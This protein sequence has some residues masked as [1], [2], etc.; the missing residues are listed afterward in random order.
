MQFHWQ[1]DPA[2]I[3]HVEEF[4]ASHEN[5]S[6]VKACV[7]KNLAK[8]KPRVDQDEFWKKMVCARLTSRQRSGPDSP[9]AQFMEKKEFPLSFADIP[10]SND[11][12][13]LRKL[14]KTTLKNH[15]GI[16]FYRRISEDLSE[17]MDRLNAEQGW[18]NMLGKLNELATTS[19]PE[20]EREVARY[21]QKLLRGFG[22]KQSRNLL[23]SLGLT[24]YEIPID[25]RVARWLKEFN[26]PVNVNAKSLADNGYYEFILDGIKILCEKSGVYP[27]VL[28]AAIFAS[29]EK[30]PKT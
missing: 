20:K 3:D 21:V 5:S 19:E 16:R 13:A 14:I 10:K 23:Q 12:D 26:F 17:N 29:F 30:T 11:G 22:P 25:S 9:V 1:V 15:G 27:C 2:D 7:K 28:D 8:T 18:T 6:F 4:F 24:R